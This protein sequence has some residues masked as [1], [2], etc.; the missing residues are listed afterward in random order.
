M[1]V[2]MPLVR[3]PVAVPVISDGVITLR[4][5]APGDASFLQEASEDPAIQRYSMSRSQPLTAAEAQEQLRDDESYRLT[6]DELGKPSGSLVIADL[7]TGAP[8]GQCGIDGWSPR[9]VAQIG[10]WLTPQARGQGLATRGVVRLTD[11][12]FDL[13]GSRV[14]LTVVEDNQASIAVAQRA[15]FR[16]EGPTGEHSVWRGTA[17]AVLGFAVT[18]DQWRQPR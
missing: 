8:F 9:D 4:P 3:V 16:L 15:G 7:A 5:W 6:A 12:L 11:W 17:H 2:N 10:Y 14:F 13:G 1:H 18:A